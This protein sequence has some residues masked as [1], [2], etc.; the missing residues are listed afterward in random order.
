M[1]KIIISE[2]KN[3]YYLIIEEDLDIFQE[4]LIEKEMI[5]IKKSLN[6]LKENV[7]EAFTNAKIE[8][9]E[10]IIKMTFL[11]KEAE[12]KAYF[13][14][15]G[16]TQESKVGGHYEIIVETLILSIINSLK[17]IKERISLNIEENFNVEISTV[18]KDV[19]E[20]MSVN[21]NELQS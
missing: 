3:S 7:S 6:I 19:I 14:E 4:A 21:F 9:T 18:S 16:L 10:A 1:I 11:K 12:F 17:I 5:N 13:K 20:E 15:G 2:L 8:F